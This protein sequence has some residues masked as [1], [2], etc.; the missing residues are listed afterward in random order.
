MLV[1]LLLIFSLISSN[2][3]LDD[4]EPNLRSPYRNISL[5]VVELLFVIVEMVR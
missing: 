3:A 1:K 5:E 2:A 4:I